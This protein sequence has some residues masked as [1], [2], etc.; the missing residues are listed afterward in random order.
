MGRDGDSTIFTVSRKLVL[1]VLLPAR[2][3]VFVYCV[4]RLRYYHSCIL[5]LNRERTTARYKSGIHIHIRSFSVF[6]DSGINNNKS[7]FSNGKT[8]CF[9]GLREC[10]MMKSIKGKLCKTFLWPAAVYARVCELSV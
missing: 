6:Y 5:C 10:C 8:N 2:A 7:F 3:E 9:T 1:T 4:P